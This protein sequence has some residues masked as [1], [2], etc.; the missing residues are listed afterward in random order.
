MVVALLSKFFR[1][2]EMG[3]TTLSPGVF[4]STNHS[5][6]MLHRVWI[7]FVTLFV[8]HCPGQAE[9]E[10]SLLSPP[11]LEGQRFGGE[12]SDVDVSLPAPAGQRRGQAFL[13]ETQCFVRLFKVSPG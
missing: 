11:P 13:Q 4:H 10:K 6:E 5:K 1:A 3:V 7:L 9:E 8:K 2:V 12:V